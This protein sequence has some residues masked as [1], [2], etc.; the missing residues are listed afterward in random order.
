VQPQLSIGALRRSPRS[1]HFGGSPYLNAALGA[2]DYVKSP[3]ALTLRIHGKLI[4]LHAR[5][6]YVNA[7]KDDSEA[8]KILEWLK[9]EINEAWE[10]R[11]EI[12]PK[13]ESRPAA[14][15]MEILKLLPRPTAGNVAKRLAR[16][17]RCRPLKG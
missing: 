5:E 8:E 13:F 17:S 3:P 6:I 1:G 10:K 15:M 2:D 7:L 9:G 11:G 4:T 16:S 12:E 14:K